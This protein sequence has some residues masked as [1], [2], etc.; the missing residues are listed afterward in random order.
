MVGGD[1]GVTT[2]LTIGASLSWPSLRTWMVY[3][4]STPGVKPDTTML[5]E[6]EVTSRGASPPWL[7]RTPSLKPILGAGVQVI[8]IVVSV[9][10]VL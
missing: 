9:T 1:S 3:V 4:Y 6:S 8:T 2:R 10:S 7:G 5:P